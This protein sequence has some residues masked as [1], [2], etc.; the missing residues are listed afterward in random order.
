M[1]D[2]DVHSADVHAAAKT[3][4]DSL[5]LPNGFKRT[6]DWINADDAGHTGREYARETVRVRLDW[7]GR[8]SWLDVRLARVRGG[9]RRRI[10]GWEDLETIV[11]G[12]PSR[13]RPLSEEE[14][15]ARVQ[16][17]VALASEV[18]ELRTRHPSPSS[19]P[20]DLSA[21]S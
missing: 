8:G 6:A 3:A 9:L 17:L 5:L 16:R 10:L 12:A 15:L 1:D 11:A 21:G 14:Q 13:V 18:L 7:D 20:A 2:R 19:T 4:F